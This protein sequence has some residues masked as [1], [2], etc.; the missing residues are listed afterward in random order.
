[1]RSIILLATITLTA[2]CAVED[3]TQDVGAFADTGEASLVDEVP[4]AETSE[5]GTL[6]I[7]EVKD[8]PGP[9]ESCHD[10]IFDWPAE[11][12]QFEAEVLAL[13]NE[14]RAN[15]ADCGVYGMYDPAPPLSYDPLLTCSARYH[16]IWISENDFSH[17]SPGGDLGDAMDERVSSA[18]YEWRMVGENIAA[19]QT[20]PK[21]VVQAWLDSDG[22]CANLM[23]PGFTELGVAYMFNPSDLYGH[24]WAQNFGTP[25]SAN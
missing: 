2:A 21:E 7:P 15:G 12:A 25:F 9:D 10:A 19:G 11:W 6:E 20:T 8:V 1:M 24:Y 23:E 5:Q 13:S 17:D 18:G 14:A 22:H 16:A 4:D 3:D